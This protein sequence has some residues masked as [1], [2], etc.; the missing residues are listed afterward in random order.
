MD[1]MTQQS[2]SVQKPHYKDVLSLIG[3]VDVFSIFIFTLPF[4]VFL[5]FVHYRGSAGDFLYV[6]Q[7]PQWV[8]G[9]YIF[10]RW[11]GM[12]AGVACCRE[13][14]LGNSHPNPFSMFFHPTTGRLLIYGF[15][16]LFVLG[17]V[18]AGVLQIFSIYSN[19]WLLYGLFIAISFPLGSWVL[20]RSFKFPLP[21]KWFISSY[22]LIPPLFIY[23]FILTVIYHLLFALV[24]MVLSEGYLYFYLDTLL[25]VWIFGVAL[26]CVQLKY[27]QYFCYR[28]SEEE[29]T[30]TFPSKS[31]DNA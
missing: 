19:I 6:D 29:Q 17:L 27:F 7:L 9:G 8:N 20:C 10:T 24:E 26:G 23:G 4:V 31:E 2:I 1:N 18:S 11:I 3:S 28:N 22:G 5:A 12:L 14:L 21:E 15:L 13:I 25:S 30:K 16:A